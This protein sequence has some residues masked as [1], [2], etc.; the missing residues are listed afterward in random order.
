M[1]NRVR[2]LEQLQELDSDERQRR[3]GTLAMAALAILLLAFAIGMVVGKAVDSAPPE[4]D[5]LDQL[6]RVA[7]ANRKQAEAHAQPS[8]AKPGAEKPLVE[9]A[10]LTF[11]RRL[12]EVE[13]RPEV[14]AALAAAEREAER[15]AVHTGAA[16]RGA[17]E[18]REAAALGEFDSDEAAIE[19]A[20]LAKPG[21]VPASMAASASNQ[22]LLRA[23]QHDKLIAQ[24]L[25]RTS[26][27]TAARGSDG[28]FTLQIISYPTQ[29][30]AESFASALRARGHEAF[31][32][33]V[34]VEGRG[35]YYRVRVGPFKTRQLAEEYRRAFE[36]RERMNTLVV[37]RDEADEG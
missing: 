36:A 11:E 25:P 20:V 3:R 8:A 15:M 33:G 19:A 22:K 4:R 21:A 10:D 32:T 9:A 37:Q 1:P 27:A 29:S 17:P 28:E 7:E 24:A 12:T 34:E 23:K 18:K 2:D 26:G 16:T 14:I 35:R 30:A 6:D 31:V 13:E 5:P